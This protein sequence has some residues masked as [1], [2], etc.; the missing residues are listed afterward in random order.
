MKKKSHNLVNVI[1]ICV[2]VTV[3]ILFI[4]FVRYLHINSNKE[5]IEI[6]QKEKLETERS[7]LEIKRIERE[8][9]LKRLEKMRAEAENGDARKKFELGQVFLN[10]FFGGV[11]IPVD[12]DE[13]SKWILK[14]AEK[15][16]PEAQFLLGSMYVDGKLSTNNYDE[17]IKWYRKAADQGYGEAQ[18]EIG[19]MYSLGTGVEEDPIEA[20]RWF[21]KGV[22]QGNATSQCNLAFM[23]LEYGRKCKTNDDPDEFI[24]LLQK[25]ADQGEDRAQRVLA[26]LYAGTY[27]K[28]I[29]VDVDYAVA[30]KWAYLADRAHYGVD[31]KYKETLNRIEKIMSQNDKIRAEK[32]IKDWKKVVR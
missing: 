30:Y 27:Y 7:D 12:N 17:A 22:E 20:A 28:G 21:A 26:E 18:N 32:L 15:N 23:I 6:L 8:Q 13:A 10:G 29:F 16:M 31:E 11:E 1:S 3:V 2:I 5:K 9:I 24:N 25:S 19:V 4:F 14:A